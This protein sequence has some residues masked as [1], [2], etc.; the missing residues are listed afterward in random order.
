VIAASANILA[1]DK[2]VSTSDKAAIMQ[3]TPPTT[4]GQV[5]F[6]NYRDYPYSQWSFHNIGGPMHVLSIPRA[7]PVRLLNNKPRQE[8]AELKLN[9]HHEQLKDVETIFAEND[10]DALVVLRGDDI[11]LERYYNGM[12]RHSQHIWFSATKSLV[13]TAFGILVEQGKVKLSDSPADHIPELKG[14]GFERTT[15]QNILNHS[16][17][18]DFHETYTDLSSDFFTRYAPAMNMAWL[19]GAQDVRP[20]ETDTFGIHDFLSN[21][22]R[23]DTALEPG[24]AFDYNSSNADVLGWLISRISGMPLQDF[25]HQ[26]IWSKLGAEHDA[27]IVVD[28]ALMPIATGGMTTSARD[29]ALFGQMILNRG[30]VDNQ[31]IIPGSWVDATLNISP[32]D[33]QKMQANKKYKHTSWIAYHNMWWLLDETKG[34]YAAV[35]IHGQVIY[36]NRSADI[37]VVFMSS[38]AVASAAKSPKFPSKLLAAQAI[39]KHLSR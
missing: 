32:K 17:A 29:A 33:K 27:L 16:S 20:T 7:G 38:Q 18:I 26:H 2:N 6:H 25:L 39:A 9:D 35:G 13:S 23:P 36:I 31:Q 10:T 5:T 3:S 22:I 1:S 8:L 30:R 4:A 24:D 19:P 21:F 14:S 34:E 28:R 11:V 12:N 37:V 15:I